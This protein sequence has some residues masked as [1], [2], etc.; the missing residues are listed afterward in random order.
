MPRTCTIAARSAVSFEHSAL[1]NVLIVDDDVEV[2]SGL[3]EA[4]TLAGVTDVYTASTFSSAQQRLRAEP[5]G[6]LLTDVRLGE[7]NGLQLALLAREL[8]PAVQIVVFSG[9]DDLVLRRDA[10][11]L[12]A[13]FLVKPVRVDQL[14][15]LLSGH[16]VRPAPPA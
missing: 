11:A 15:G 7:Y 2:L 3:K 10:E 12:G 4:L 16:Q 14:I 1:S 5:V 6:T 13:V 9:F 8:N